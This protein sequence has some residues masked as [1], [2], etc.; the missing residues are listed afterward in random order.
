MKKRL[1]S[2]LLSILLLTLLSGC[3]DKNNQTENSE[4]GACPSSETQ[5][6]APTEAQMKIPYTP[7]ELTLNT[8]VLNDVGSTLTELTEKY[9]RIS[10]YSNRHGGV[11]LKFEN[12]QGKCFLFYIDDAINQ[13]PPY[14][15]YHKLYESEAPYLQ[16]DGTQHDE[17]GRFVALPKESAACIGVEDLNAKKIFVD[18]PDIITIYDI[19]NIEG[20]ENFKLIRNDRFLTYNTIF[21]YKGSRVTLCHE[22]I[23]TINLA[24]YDDDEQV[25]EYSNGCAVLRMPRT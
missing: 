7:I 10:E 5:T 13:E 21:E 17:N 6:E 12:G 24:V 11:S 4:P 8:D 19:Q 20:I 25:W 16:F 1:Q 22:D 15:P 23:E 3:A 2:I 14:Q 9:G 18:A